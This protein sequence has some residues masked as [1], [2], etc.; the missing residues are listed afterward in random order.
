MSNTPGE[1][2]MNNDPEL[3]RRWR[4]ILGRYAEQT[5]P[6]SSTDSDLE[7]TLSF[8]Y[9]REYT[10]RGHRHASGKGGNLAASELTALK[11]LGKARRLFPHSTLE[12][13]ERDAITR[14]GLDD[15]LADPAAVDSIHASPDLAK[16]LLRSKGK[17]SPATA[18]G[19]RTIIAKIV[20][21]IVERIRPQFTTALTG[22]RVRH[23]RSQHASLRNLDW[24]GT[25][26][27]NLAHV[28]PET[29]KML[30]EEVRFMSRKRRRNLD[31][32]VIILVDQSG[33][34]A[35]SVL[36]SAICA[37]I[38]AGLPG[39]SVRLVLFDT[40]VVDMTHL[41][42]DPVEVLMTAQLGGGTN[43]AQAMAYAQKLIEQPTRTVVALISDFE[44]GGSVSSLLSSTQALA[45][46][47]ARLLGLASLDD[48]GDPWYDRQM[49]ARLAAR[50]MDIAAMTPDRF[51]DWLAEV[52][53]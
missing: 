23:Q 8:L 9:D 46:S 41:A 33:S 21:D 14:Y 12:R 51:A 45:S 18:E 48:D 3:T 38:M 44:E 7:N 43:I 28:D 20:A 37:A 25:I 52:T 49:A 5:L 16:A 32:Q 29:G 1:K 27:A 4:L 35:G 2:T 36:H 50:G 24:R 47:G 42:N 30:I 31:W 22:S 39:I 11:W 40:S 19:V 17:L 10:E 26:G 6:T 53:Q 34:M 13:M 15:L